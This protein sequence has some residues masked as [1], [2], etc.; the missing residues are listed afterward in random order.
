MTFG[1]SRCPAGTP[2]VSGKTNK[3]GWKTESSRPVYQNPW[4]S[5]KEDRIVYPNGQPGIYGVVEKGPGVAVIALDKDRNIYL[6]KQYRYTLD[7]VFLE[8]PAGA[9]HP[10]ETETQ[11]AQRELFEEIGL[12]AGRFD[13]LGNFYTALGHETA[14]IIAYLAQDLDAEG[15][16]LENQQHDES[17][18]EIVRLSI[19]QAK[20]VIARGEIKC[21]ISLATLNLFFI[22]YP[23]P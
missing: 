5:V 13:R 1:N 16:S 7:D 18:L 11:S 23:E 19:G 2:A 8:L 20:E 15:H 9:I 6:V 12:R 22:K 17:I 21:G 4:I 14:E 10:G 3:Y